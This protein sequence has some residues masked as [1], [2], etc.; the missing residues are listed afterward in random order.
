MKSARRAYD[1]WCEKP[2]EDNAHPYFEVGD[3]LLIYP[4]M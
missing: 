4:G 3:M 1:A 2:L